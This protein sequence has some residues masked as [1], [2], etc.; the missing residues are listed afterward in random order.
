MFLLY[1][2]GIAL[3]QAGIKLAAKWNEKAGLLAKGQNGS[4]SILRE[5][6]IPGQ[7]YVWFHASSLGEFEQGRPLIEELKRRFPEQ[8]VILTFFSPS[9]YEVRKN[10]TG[11]DVVLYLPMDT[12]RNV[13]RFLDIVKPEK[14]VFIKYEFWANYLTEL[15][16]R[17]IPTYLV[18]AIF[19]PQQA[20][21]KWYGG[22]YRG[23]LSAFTHLYVQDKPSEELLKSIGV[24]NVTVAGDTRF[25]RVAEIAA[26]AKELPLVE[27]FAKGRRVLVAGSSWPLD[28]D[29]LF[30]YFNSHEDLFLIVAPHVTSESHIEDICRK[31]KRPFARYTKTDEQHA[32]QA[33][34]LIIDC[35]GLLSSIY[36]YG[37]IAYIGGGFGVGIHNVLE[38]AVYGVPVVFGP[39][40][41]KF[42]E[43]CGLIDAGGGFSISESQQYVSLMDKLL[44]NTDYLSSCGK[45][46][47][48][49]VDGNLGAT[50]LIMHKLA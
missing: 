20:F 47:A 28:E 18:S 25:D 3:Y 30:D 4:F 9:G 16:R 37:Q 14:A 44:Q 31:L 33:D 32:A 23:L 45:N 49:F 6:I 40:Y 10:Y 22:W 12:P 42:R 27:A 2:S 36:R 26:Q 7:K 8:K 41:H 1:N 24:T 38:A 17:G 48:T 46:S 50:D 19:R 13:C 15:K 39:N 11:A 5:K 34:C 43:A 35:I 29:I 21:F